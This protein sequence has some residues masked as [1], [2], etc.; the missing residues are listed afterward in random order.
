MFYLDI[1][2]G[3]NSILM[4]LQYHLMM[5]FSTGL[6]WSVLRSFGWTRTAAG[7]VYR[8]WMWHS[9]AKTRKKV[10]RRGLRPWPLRCLS[11]F[12]TERKYRLL[13]GRMLLR[14]FHRWGGL[15]FI[16][17]IIPNWRVVR[18]FSHWMGYFLPF[19]GF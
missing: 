1:K 11:Q 4:L 17:Y 10:G 2:Y 3:L 9:S 16:V 12:L 6:G 5:P 14:T 15:V 7:L 18:I 19:I 13:R 8:L